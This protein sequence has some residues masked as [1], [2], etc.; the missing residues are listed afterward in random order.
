MFDALDAA[1]CSPRPNGYGWQAQCPAHE[2]RSPSLSITPGDDKVLVHCFAGCDTR[3]V[4]AA[5]RLSFADLYDEPREQRAAAPAQRPDRSRAAAPGEALRHRRRAAAPDPELPDLLA[6][7]GTTTD[8]E[9]RAARG[10]CSDVSQEPPA[11]LLFSAPPGGWDPAV[12][13][14]AVRLAERVIADD[15]LAARQALCHP[16][17]DEWLTEDAIVTVA[18]CSGRC[19]DDQHCALIRAARQGADAHTTWRLDEVALAFV[20]RQRC[21]CADDEHRSLVRAAR[22]EKP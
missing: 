5:L 17:G 22:R 10:S 20:A 8:A 15:E 3:D 7:F 9:I 11:P 1:G 12:T 6:E 4:L 13:R 16:G 14:E 2:D 19:T 18:R 21:R